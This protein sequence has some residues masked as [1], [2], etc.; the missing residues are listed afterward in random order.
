LKE[1]RRLSPVAWTDSQP[2][3]EEIID[4]LFPG[5]PLI[6]V[7]R[8]KYEFR[9]APREKFRGLL[10]D[11]QFI[12]PSAMSA[13]FGLTQQGKKSMHSLA[14]TGPRQ[15]LVI[16]FDQGTMDEQATILAHLMERGRLALSSLRMMAAS[17]MTSRSRKGSSVSLHTLSCRASWAAGPLL[18]SSHPLG[19]RRP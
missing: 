7:G 3:T 17:S 13:P 6:C 19:G 11:L 8:S 9:T 18:S 2:H 5:N 12:V 1:L 15:Y 10:S 4:E 16:E 14:N